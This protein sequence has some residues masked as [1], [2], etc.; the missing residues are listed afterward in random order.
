MIIIPKNWL[1]GCLKNFPSRKV[2]QKWTHRTCH[3][4]KMKSCPQVDRKKFERYINHY[5]EKYTTL[6][7]HKYTMYP[8]VK[9]SNISKVTPKNGSFFFKKLSKC[10]SFRLYFYHISPMG[11][12]HYWKGYN[13]LWFFSTAYFF[14]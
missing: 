13:T 8:F 9:T 11:P 6:V 14:S 10:Q 5:L 4:K 12:D 1:Q 3:K 2:C 7:V